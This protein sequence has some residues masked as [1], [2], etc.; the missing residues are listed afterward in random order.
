MAIDRTQVKV[1]Q[2]KFEDYRDVINEI[3]TDSFEDP[4][5]LSG[6]GWWWVA[7]HDNKPVGFAGLQP[8]NQWELTGYLYRA[9]LT[10]EARGLRLQRRLIAARIAKARK[11][12]W[13]WLVT[14]TYSNPAS[15]NNLIAM[16]FRLYQPKRP[17]AAKGSLYW[18]MCLLKGMR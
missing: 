7:F 14:D 4:P 17:W 11:L 1:R 12:G 13:H 9:A 6:D 5:R 2:V 18:R 16:G 15:A 3:H 10:W 8:S